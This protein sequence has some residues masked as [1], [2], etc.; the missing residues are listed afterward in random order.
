MH[1]FIIGQSKQFHLSI[2]KGSHCLYLNFHL[3]VTLS[4]ICTYFFK[5]LLVMSICSLD[6]KDLDF[7]QVI[8]N[9]FGSGFGFNIFRSFPIDL[10]HYLES[11]CLELHLTLCCVSE[12][13]TKF[14]HA[15]P[16]CDLHFQSLFLTLIQTR[17]CC[18]F[19]KF[20]LRNFLYYSFLENI[21]QIYVVLIEQ[22]VHLT[23]S[24][25][26]ALEGLKHFNSSQYFEFQLFMVHL[27]SLLVSRESIK[28]VKFQETKV[29]IS[30]MCS[31]D[32]YEQ[33]CNL[34]PSYSFAVIMIMP[35]YPLWLV[36]DQYHDL[37]KQRPYVVSF[38]LQQQQLKVKNLID[39]HLRL[40]T[41]TIQKM[42][43]V[44]I[45]D[46]N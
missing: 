43:L 29:L 34:A 18:L 3:I 28:E 44:L 8:L 4:L 27:I 5:I 42:G 24:R 23:S 35:L 37:T 17:I 14:L 10:F 1:V 6:L 13:F 9:R 11:V 40:P 38:L 26:L 20:I 36:S 12:Y 16:R 31:L 33:V 21:H 2:A 7:L 46:P 32:L 45:V 30:N 25:G 41:F 22:E 19:D 15:Q 39:F